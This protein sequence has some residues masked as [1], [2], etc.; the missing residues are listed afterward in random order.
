MAD[1]QRFTFTKTYIAIL[2]AECTI[3]HEEKQILGPQ[4]ATISCSDL[5]VTWQLVYYWTASITEWAVLRP[6]C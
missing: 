5:P 6:Y 4:Y 3:S 1:Q 2:M